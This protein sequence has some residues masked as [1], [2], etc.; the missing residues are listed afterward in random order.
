VHKPVS[1]TKLKYNTALA[2]F[3]GMLKEAGLC[4]AEYGLHSP[5]VGAATEAYQNRVPGHIIDIRGRWKS[6]SSKKRYCRPSEKSWLP[7][8]S[9]KLSKFD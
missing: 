8:V 4:A 9:K 3:K 6:A 1:N 2:C 7:I 5:R